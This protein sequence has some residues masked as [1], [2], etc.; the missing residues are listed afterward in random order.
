IV[1]ILLVFSF[2]VTGLIATVNTLAEKSPFVS[3]WV[4]PT[5]VH[6]VDNMLVEFILPFLVTFLF[7]FILFKWIPEKK[8]KTAAALLAALWSALLWETLK[9][10]YTYYLVHV[11]VLRKIESPIVAI[12][13]FGF[14][15]ELTMSIM[16]YGAKLT[17]LL[18]KEENGKLK[19]TH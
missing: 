1:G 12:I 18:D 5:F 13:L 8:V 9:R 11:S 14:W 15:M 19:K 2:L 3:N 17:F 16:L 6:A 4:D 10:A 7:F